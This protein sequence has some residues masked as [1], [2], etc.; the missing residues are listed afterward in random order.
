M[1]NKFRIRPSAILLGISLAV[2]LACLP[3]W[4]ELQTRLA[5]AW[6]WPTSSQPVTIET[7]SPDP[8]PANFTSSISV[9]DILDWSRELLQSR[10]QQLPQDQTTRIILTGDV[11]FGRAVAYN[12]HRKNDFTYPLAKVGARLKQADLA[13]VNLEAPIFAGCPLNTEGMLLCAD[14]Q[15][16]SALNFAGIDIV[17]L[18]NNHALDYGPQALD[19]TKKWALAQEI[20]SIGLGQAAIKQVRATKF[21]FLAYSQFAAQKGLISP[22]SP[23][24]ITQDLRELKNEAEVAIVGFHW[25]QEY[26]SHPTA[27]QISLAHAAID[28]GAD[29]VFGHHPH[30]VQGIEIY[31]GKP[32]FYSLGNFV[33][34]QMESKQ[35]REG[36]A[37]QLDYWKNNLIEARVLPIYMEDFAQPDWQPVGIG[38]ATI[39]KV[40]RLSEELIIP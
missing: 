17:Q 6:V 15:A 10:I 39:G 9:N 32:I 29:V 34:D 16:F 27:V 31:Q 33:F 5:N 21:G 3:L 12:M 11:M 38:N 36:I 8:N 40:E 37:V 20:D 26:Q 13:M 7:P 25:G 28:A 14:A 19:Y 30:W 24:L 18:A 22:A 1:I 2:G 23:E 35:T 4:L